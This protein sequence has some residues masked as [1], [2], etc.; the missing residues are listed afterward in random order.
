MDTQQFQAKVYLQVCR[1]A[2]VMCEHVNYDTTHSC[3]NCSR[4]TPTDQ[5]IF[6]VYNSDHCYV[7]F[8][9]P[10][11]LSNPLRP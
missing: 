3:T 2:T 6:T 5:N 7:N 4:L 10:Y 11:P 8:C 1:Y 9:R